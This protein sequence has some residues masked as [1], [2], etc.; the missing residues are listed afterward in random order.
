M[1]D[2]AAVLGAECLVLTSS[3]HRT[4]LLSMSRVEAENFVLT[5]MSQFTQD[6]FYKQSVL[7]SGLTGSCEG[8][9][10]PVTTQAK[11]RFC[12][13]FKNKKL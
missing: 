7:H 1:K 11:P 4:H 5:G 12:V 3:S 10:V 9:K 13:Y 6:A 8:L 2:L